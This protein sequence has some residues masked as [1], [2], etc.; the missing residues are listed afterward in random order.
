[1]RITKSKI[2]TFNNIKN[3]IKK[4]G[5]L[6][7]NEKP[8]G[9]NTEGKNTEGENP[10]EP[11]G[12]NTE[13]E[14][15]EEPEGK[16]TEGENPEEPEGKNTEGENPKGEE[17]EV[18]KNEIQECINKLITHLNEKVINNAKLNLETDVKNI[19]LKINKLKLFLV[20][21][22]EFYSILNNLSKNEK[23]KIG[24]N[25]NLIIVDNRF[26]EYV[27]SK[28]LA[29]KL[30][31]DISWTD[32]Q[33]KNYK[34]LL[35]FR[36]KNKPM[37]FGGNQEEEGVQDEEGHGNK[38]TEEDEEGPGNQGDEGP[39]TDDV[40]SDE[41]NFT[42]K[43]KDYTVILITKLQLDNVKNIDISVPFEDLCKKLNE[44]ALLSDFNN[45]LYVEL[46]KSLKVEMTKPGMNQQTKFHDLDLRVN[47]RLNE[48]LYTK[49]IHGKLEDDDWPSQEQVNTFIKGINRKGAWTQGMFSKKSKESN[50]NPKSSMFSWGKKKK[51]VNAAE[52]VDA[53][54]ED[55][56]QKPPTSS[57][58]KKNIRKNNV[59]KKTKIKKI[60]KKNLKI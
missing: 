37:F 6:Q 44:L 11:E 14:N 58:G 26:S 5:G 13:G 19:M 33:K 43:F 9:K 55:G 54:S 25:K 8:K 24:K 41:N 34:K 46:N 4:S 17:T 3:H 18:K 49:M 40:K 22:K 35:Q 38:G 20:F 31:S 50:N 60:Y 27:F 32:S 56:N 47:K 7:T 48:V 57:G 53:S 2:K 51:E 12:K 45:S 30:I 15:P 29:G 10:E 1:M 59:I 23:G 21:N 28:I 36:Q 16:N 52:E 42:S 39:G